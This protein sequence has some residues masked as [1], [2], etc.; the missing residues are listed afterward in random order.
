MTLDRITENKMWSLFSA[1][2]QSSGKRIQIE[3][4]RIP[5]DV[6]R[7]RMEEGESVMEGSI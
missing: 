2:L 7:V 6:E 4:Y 5:K 3:R 1:S